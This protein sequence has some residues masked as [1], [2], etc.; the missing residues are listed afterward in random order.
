MTRYFSPEL[1]IIV[2]AYN[3]A[4]ELPACLSAIRAAAA[5]VGHEI[6]VVDNASRD[7]TLDLL[8][9][10]SGI[11]L[12]PSAVNLGFAAGNNLAWR[13]ARGRYL[14]LV[15]PDAR[16]DAGSLARA[17]RWMDAHPQVGL[18][19][20]RLLS[21]DGNDQP[22]A[23]SFPSLLN[24]LLVISGLSSRFARSRFFGRV[25]RT[26]ADPAEAAAVDWV[27][28]AFAVIRC[29]ALDEEGLF[30]ERFFLYFEEVDLCRR[31]QARGFSVW[32]QPEWRAVHIGGVS[33]QRVEGEHFNRHGSQLS[34]WRMRSALLYYRKHH[35]WLGA[36]GASWL[37]RLWHGL[38]LWRNRLQ[39]R[40][41]AQAR[42]AE[43][44]ALSRLLARAWQDTAGGRS[45]PPRP[46]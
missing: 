14:A 37:E 24:D 4:P 33:S 10:E 26:W 36:F 19:G 25:D 34:L 2:V 28:G 6:L 21:E 42:C 8:R 13:Q 18:A 12:L 20:G 1:S 5:G 32:Y 41:G 16:P 15:N 44:L 3:S 9:F 17:V 23:R 43:S 38:R 27:P 46:W 11:R 35:G 39:Q 40:Q 30:D 29:S 31:L 45:S 22:S 7:D